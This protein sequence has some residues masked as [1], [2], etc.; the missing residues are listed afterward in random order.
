MAWSGPSRGG[1]GLR[2]TI[3]RHRTCRPD[4]GRGPPRMLAPRPP[5]ST[6]TAAAL[7]I[8]E[9]GS[10]SRCRARTCRPKGG[11]KAYPGLRARRE[12]RPRPSRFLVV[13]PWLRRRPRPAGRTGPRH[14]RPTVVRATPW[15]PATGEKARRSGWS[16]SGST[17]HGPGWPPRRRHLSHRGSRAA[18][19][20]RRRRGPPAERAASSRGRAGHHTARQPFQCRFERFR[21]APVVLDHN[22]GR[23][24]QPSPHPQC[25][26]GLAAEPS[27][28]TGQG[29]ARPDRRCAFAISAY[30]RGGLRATRR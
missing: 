28:P 1:S 29:Q 9:P 8:R 21:V 11:T 15:S 26:G 13:G 12:G 2:G 27:E 25:V 16:A 17:R 23:S 20:T 24:V 6:P 19:P 3:A 10:P 18:S 14:G 5:P 4:R 7:P 22:V 30:S